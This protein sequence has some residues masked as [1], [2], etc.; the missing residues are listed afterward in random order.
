MSRRTMTVAQLISELSKFPQHLPVY[1]PREVLGYCCP[2]PII[3]KG[4]PELPQD[5]PEWHEKVIL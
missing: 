1:V 5:D 2:A 4:V 3:V